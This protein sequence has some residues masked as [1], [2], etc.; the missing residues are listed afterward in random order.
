[1]SSS[2]PP[3]PYTP[4]TYNPS[5]WSINGANITTD[6]LDANYLRFNYAQGS[7]NFVGIVNI[8]SLTQ[9]GASQFGTAD[10]AITIPTSIADYS[11]VA[12]N[13]AS[14]KVPTTAWVQTAITG[15]SGASIPVARYYIGNIVNT[16]GIPSPYPTINFANIST[17]NY[18][19]GIMFRVILTFQINTSSTSGSSGSVTNNCN[20]FSANMM[21]FPKAFITG[22]NIPVYFNNGIGATTTNTTYAPVSSA[23][24]AYVANGRPYWSSGITND[25]N[26]VACFLPSLTN[27]GTT[28]SLIL[29]MRV[30]GKNWGIYRTTI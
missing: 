15:G 30:H 23:M 3:S 22:N 17:K 9:T 4:S 21:V 16:S 28:A 19:D 12:S 20:S 10:K 27:N 11:G 18:W 6:Y 29:K 26:C 8:G 1:M 25:L 14:T 13:D 7:E 5:A 24:S 2:N